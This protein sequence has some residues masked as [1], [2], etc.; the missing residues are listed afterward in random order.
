MD[1]GCLIE[2]L[3]KE[4]LSKEIKLE[5]V[6]SDNEPLQ[7]RFGERAFQAEGMARGNLTQN[8]KEASNAGELQAETDVTGGCISQSLVG[9]G[10]CWDF[11]MSMKGSHWNSEA[12]SGVILFTF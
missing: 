5:L 6:P 3:G 9:Q 12:V 10:K 2:Q 1:S 4:D 11:I 8:R 7:S